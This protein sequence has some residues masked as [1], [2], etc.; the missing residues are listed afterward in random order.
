[1]SNKLSLSKLI[2]YILNKYLFNQK[3]EINQKIN[4]NFIFFNDTPF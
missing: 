4:K 1:M 3:M 2:I